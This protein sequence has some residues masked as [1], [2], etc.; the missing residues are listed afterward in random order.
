MKTVTKFLLLFA[1]LGLIAAGE[2]GEAAKVITVTGSWSET[3]D[4]SDLVAGAGSDLIG[5]YESNSDQIVLDIDVGGG[6]FRVDVSKI[7]TNWH[8]DF[9][10]YVR[11]TSD[12]TGDGEI[13]GGTSYQE[14]TDTYQSF[15]TLKKDRTGINLQL[16]LSGVSVQVA[17]DTYTTTAYYTIVKI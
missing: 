10:L 11:R 16:K 17:P 2:K 9:Q 4:A 8:S 1:V 7:N 3:I 12:G 15:F 13:S 6:N 5:T 14:I